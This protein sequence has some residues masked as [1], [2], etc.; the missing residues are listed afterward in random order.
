MSNV[1]FYQCLYTM[2][3]F[4]YPMCEVIPSRKLRIQ[5]P[6]RLS[7]SCSLF[8]LKDAVWPCFTCFH[9]TFPLKF[10]HTADNFI[11]RACHIREIGVFLLQNLAN[12]ETPPMVV[13]NVDSEIHC[14]CLSI[15]IPHTTQQL[16]CHC[17]S[18]LS[19][20]F[21]RTENL[22]SLRISTFLDGTNN[23]FLTKCSRNPPSERFLE[24][25]EIPGR[26]FASWIMVSLRPSHQAIPTDAALVIHGVYKLWLHWKTSPCL[27]C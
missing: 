5:D 20:L 8:L 7:P 9:V 11:C 21:K 23:R 1:I 2:F 25:Q 4:D 15:P 6:P 12:R 18:R 24:F 3:C 16:L 13:R 19:Y 26:C 22:K 27:W 17:C 10:R 14:L